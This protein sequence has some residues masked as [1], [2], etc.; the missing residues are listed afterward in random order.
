MGLMVKGCREERKCWRN[1][2]VGREGMWEEERIVVEEEDLESGVWC[3]M[4]RN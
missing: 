2:D 3:N 4:R 1:R